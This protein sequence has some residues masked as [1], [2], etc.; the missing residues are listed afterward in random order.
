[1][2][3]LA[4]GLVGAGYIG[5][6]G[7]ETP[8]PV[9]EATAQPQ[10]AAM[11]PAYRAIVDEYCVTCHN[12]RARTA[13]L[14]LE[15]VDLENLR[16]HG[17]VWE[18]VLVKLR[19]RVMPPVDRSRPDE[20]TYQKLIT[21]IESALDRAG[22]AAPRPRRPLARRLTRVEYT[23]AIRDLLALEIN[24]ASLLPADHV[25]YGFDNIGEVLSVSPLLMERYLFAADR[26]SRRAVG[27][28]ASAPV[29]DTYRVSS[30]FMQTDRSSEDLPFGSRGGIAVR[31]DFPADG[32]YVIR[33]RL[34]R[35]QYGYIRGL[36]EP[37]QL[38][39][40]LDGARVKLLSIGGEFRGRSGP[41][42]TG[43]RNAEFSGDPAQVE[44]EF[45]AD[46]ALETR[47]AAK[48][49]PRQVAAAFVNRRVRPTGVRLPQ[50]VFHDLTDYKG[51]EPAVESITI[52]GPYNPTGRSETPSR[53]RIFVCT[54]TA[55][56]DEEPCAK[57][58]LATLGR[59]AYRRPLE[60]RELDALLQLYRT[61]RSEGP[62]FESGIQMALQGVLAGP[63]FLFRI[64]HEPADIPAGAPHRVHDLDLASRL[65]FFLWS[66]IPDDELL[67]LAERGELSQKAILHQQVLRMLADP[68]AEALVTNFAGQ[69]FS[70]RNLAAVQ[71]EPREFPDFDGELRDAMRLETEL[72]VASLLR[73]DRSVVELLT[74]D[75]TFLNERL[76]RHYGIANVYGSRFRRVQLPDET[77]RGLLGHGSFLTVTSYAN[78]TSPVLRG[79][80]VLEQLL[81][82]APPPPPPD[83]PALE[84]KSKKD[85]KPLTM[86]EALVQN[87]D[88]PVCST[89]HKL[90]DPIGFALEN[91][92][93]VGSYR[94]IDRTDSPIVVDGR[95]F[96]GT[97][98]NGVVEFRQRLLAHK[99]RFVHT[100]TRKLMTYALG[101]PVEHD[102]LPVVR[103]IMR[104]A[105]PSGYRWSAL[106]MGI[107][108]S[109]PFQMS[110]SGTPHS[111]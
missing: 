70:L 87:Q 72:L 111:N 68:R 24:G 91:F 44:Y 54:P 50:M 103:G 1:V 55:V 17:E 38:D 108:E 27:E 84:E 101:R 48:A 57:K 26:I 31:H 47:F 14:S 73:E 15:H 45:A 65:S 98:F 51:G 23:N 5:V 34:Q 6:A 61:G 63:E 30:Y 69:W 107:V 19:L 36:G 43:N 16:E 77:R 81:D 40:R 89:C 59:R 109:A 88:K 10:P 52:A 86:R 33:I 35:T 18:K 28:P 11:I 49:G 37:H 76:A 90:M 80:W 46:E 93:A 106:I 92:D 8:A 74:A 71:P 13:N 4:I 56:T 75:Y 96:D 82:M 78:R 22:A 62:H 105:A 97:K 58:I 20:A 102:D 39:V 85:G 9:P 67:D 95:L 21:E 94:T 64:E 83:V 104:D 99:E 42:W 3:V 110:S 12:D 53:R 25:G 29:A 2:W 79:K 66:S 32:D 41:L 100:A 60:S 7:Q